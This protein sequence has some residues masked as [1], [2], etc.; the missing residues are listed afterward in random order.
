MLHVW[1]ERGGGGCTEFWSGSPRERDHR[2][3]LVVDEMVVLK[4]IF[5]SYDGGM[6]SNVL[7]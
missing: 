6:D 7:M 2:G 5:K 4:W 3:D 1:G